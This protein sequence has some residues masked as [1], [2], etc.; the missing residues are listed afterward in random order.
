MALDPW[1]EE[2]HVGQNARP[3]VVFPKQLLKSQ[4]GNTSGLATQ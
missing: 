4:Q 2:K 3:I 1:R